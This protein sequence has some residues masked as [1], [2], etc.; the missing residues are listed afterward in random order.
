MNQHTERILK[1]LANKKTGVFCDDSNLFYAY[2]KYNWRIDFK[3]LK[4][5]LNQYCDLKF[6]N[7]HVAI[8][9]KSDNARGKSEKF[10]ANINRDV[11]LKKKDLKYI[12]FS[13]GI[14]KKGDVDINV[15]LDVVRN[16]DNLDAV[17]ILSGDSDYLEL[18]N[19]VVKDKQKEIIF[20]SYKRNMAWELKRYC[21]TIFLEKIKDYIILENNKP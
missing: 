11:V 10:L 7:Y 12:P 3:K 9:A 21:K 5:F 14:T 8:P 4:N 19:Y 1:N 15:A 6:I 13:K 20:M 16:I 2:K 17:I 18:K